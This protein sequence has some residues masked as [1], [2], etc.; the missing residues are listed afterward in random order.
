[1]FSVADLLATGFEMFGEIV[2]ELISHEIVRLLTLS[3]RFYDD[4][5]RS[6]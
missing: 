1:V 4:D 6:W 3:G 2:L 5:R